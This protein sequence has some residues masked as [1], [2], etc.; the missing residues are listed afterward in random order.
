MGEDDFSLAVE[1]AV[2]RRIIWVG[3]ELDME[4]A[5]RL[6]E[7]LQSLDGAPI[8]VDFSCVTFMDSA[9]IAVIVRAV[10]HAA[11]NASTFALRNVQPNQRRLLEL[12]GLA[13]LCDDD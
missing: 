5:P 12:V 10:K 9:G 4:T 3:G 7:C 8:T 13:D 6:D 11:H 2:D 1:E